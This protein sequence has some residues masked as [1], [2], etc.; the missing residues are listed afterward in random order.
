MI[1]KGKEVAKHET[2]LSEVNPSILASLILEGNI[3]KLN[4]QQR[5]E[6]VTKLCER[7]GVDPLTQPFKILKLNGREVL[8]ADKG[9][10]QQLCKV[11]DISTEV[12]EKEKIEDIYIVTVRASLPNGRFT[13]ED[14]AVTIGK[15]HGDPLANAMMKAVTKAK[16]RAVLALC[17]LGM[18]DETEIETIPGA[19]TQEVAEKPKF[20]R[21]MP[22]NA[23][24][25]SG[26]GSNL[27]DNEEK[28]S[29]PT[30]D[31][32]PDSVTQE[33]LT[34]LIALAIKNMYAPDDIIQQFTSLG[35]GFE[36][37][38]KKDLQLSQIS[39]ELNRW[40]YE[41]IYGFISEVK[42]NDTEE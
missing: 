13:D 14:G 9:C 28:V 12:K 35:Y 39:P 22:E 26:N 4:P 34:E 36:G 18:L 15:L 31:M 11:Y 24:T 33:E 6:Y 8:Y 19:T 17:G 37:K 2:S 5:V 30:Q 27:N 41:T 21:P 3:G 40:D 16:R 1:K 38:V 29:E 23:P 25:S 10:S 7:V 20:S 42:K 32:S